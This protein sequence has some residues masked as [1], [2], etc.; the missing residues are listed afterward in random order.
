MLLVDNVVA[1]P[2]HGVRLNVGEEDPD[3]VQIDDSGAAAAWT[4]WCG[5]FPPLLHLIDRISGNVGVG[6]RPR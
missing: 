4:T 1:D 6:V 2:R 3:P 5:G